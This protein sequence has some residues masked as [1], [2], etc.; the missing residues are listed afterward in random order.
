MEIFESAMA[1]ALSF[2]CAYAFA[3]L[4]PFPKQSLPASEH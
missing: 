4:V 3:S 1:I 2:N